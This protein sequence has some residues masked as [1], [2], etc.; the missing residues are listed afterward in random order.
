MTKYKKRTSDVFPEGNIDADYQYYLGQEGL[1][2]L[3]LGHRMTKSERAK[4]NYIWNS[5]LKEY[6][7]VG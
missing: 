2:G 4:A 3:L 7:K 1:F 6:N 5:L